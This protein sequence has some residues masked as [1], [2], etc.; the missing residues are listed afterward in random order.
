[1]K[2]FLTSLC[3]LVTLI[4]CSYAVSTEKPRQPPNTWSYGFYQLRADTSIW[5]N[6]NRVQLDFIKRDSVGKQSKYIGI[7]FN[8]WPID[9]GEFRVVRWRDTANEVSIYACDRE[10][11]YV[12]RDCDAI[13]HVSRKDRKLII[14]ANGVMMEEMGGHGG[15]SE[16]AVSTAISFNLVEY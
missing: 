6:A 10:H 8:Q 16:E 13:V 14:W 5:R 11:C 3:I 7:S 4:F 12:S 9:T 2:P 1:M 15:K